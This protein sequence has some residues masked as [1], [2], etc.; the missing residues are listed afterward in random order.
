MNEAKKKTCSPQKGGQ[1]VSSMTLGDLLFVSWMAILGCLFRKSRLWF[2]EVGSLY[3]TGHQTLLASMR[4]SPRPYIFLIIRT[5]RARRG[6][7]TKNGAVPIQM[8]DEL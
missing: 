5:E 2:S 6:K 4:S 8:I 7:R 3:G 1:Q